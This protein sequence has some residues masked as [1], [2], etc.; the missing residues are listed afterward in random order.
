MSSEPIADTGFDAWPDELLLRVLDELAP[1]DIL[2]SAYPVCKRFARVAGDEGLWRQI[3]E[4]LLLAHASERS[5]T[6]VSGRWLR[7]AASS[8]RAHAFRDF[9][10]DFLRLWSPRFGW[11]ADLAGL[12]GNI[13]RVVPDFDAG[14]VALLRLVVFNGLQ[15]LPTHTVPSNALAHDD[16]LLVP[17]G[18]SH[19]HIKLLHPGMQL[20]VVDTAEYVA[21]DATQ[22]SSSPVQQS[23][24]GAD[25]A[26]AALRPWRAPLNG[27]VA[28]FP[29]PALATA[30]RLPAGAAITRETEISVLA[31][32]RRCF[33]P[34]LSPDDLVDDGPVR[35]G[36]YAGTYDAHGFE[37]VYIHTVDPAASPA[38]EIPWQWETL[39]DYAPAHGRRIEAVKI[40]GDENVPK[41]QRTFVAFLSAPQT[42]IHDVP[43]TAARSLYKP[44]PIVDDDPRLP[45]TV[46]SDF[47]SCESGITAP[48]L[49]RVAHAGFQLP[50]W[51]DC[52]VH[53]ASRVEIEVYW[54]AWGSVSTFRRLGDAT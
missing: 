43:E 41:G 21:R 20:H 36:W 35:A 49:G 39:P 45:A 12:R 53:V 34:L 30:L 37:V 2:I 26:D 29:P 4:R 40:T 54:P 47:Y 44:W 15:S 24:Y 8:G 6:F 22:P 50:S 52:I 18:R 31:F 27:T 9:W 32:D 51:L 17:R 1:Q 28:P 3:C 38:P 23:A 19:L 14:A 13:F 33:T 10:R 7:G 16:D 46:L 11:W 5:V 42:R 25:I 48:G